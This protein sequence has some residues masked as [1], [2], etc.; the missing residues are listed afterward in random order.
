MTDKLAV[1]ING[2]KVPRIKKILLYEMKFVVPNYSCLQNPRLGGYCPQIPVLSVLCPQLN[3]LNS[4]PEQ[5]SWVCH[6]SEGPTLDVYDDDDDDDDNWDPNNVRSVL[7]T[8]FNKK[9]WWWPYRGQNMQPTCII[10]WCVWHILFYY[11]NEWLFTYYHWM[12]NENV[13][14]AVRAIF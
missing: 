11:F 1:I 13:I 6:W 12:T 3:L 9:A 5:N 4:T 10:N 14:C 8:W 7:V 2:F